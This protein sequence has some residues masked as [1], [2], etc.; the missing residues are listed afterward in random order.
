MWRGATWR[1]RAR[2]AFGFGEPGVMDKAT[3]NSLAADRRGPTQDDQA[4]KA[5]L[6]TGSCLR[7]LDQG[8]GP[9]RARSSRNRPLETP[10]TRGW[11]GSRVGWTSR[12]HTPNAAHFHGNTR[13]GRGRAGLGH[14]L[15]EWD[16]NELSNGSLLIEEALPVDHQL[17][18]Q[19]V[20]RSA[21]P[22]EDRLTLAEA[23]GSCWRRTARILHGLRRLGQHMGITLID[24]KMV[25]LHGCAPQF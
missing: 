6:L 5:K 7:I 1:G 13:S 4:V 20:S 21:V 11:A 18:E 3:A 12:P 16:C 9:T 14:A 15:G 23:W 2:Q 17:L 19:G 10:R 22:V 24:K 25:Q 8:L